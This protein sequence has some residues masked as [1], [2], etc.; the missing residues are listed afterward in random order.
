[1]PNRKSQE[2]IPIYTDFLDNPIAVGDTIIYPI[3][4]GSS[5]AST[6]RTIVTEIIALIPDP[7]SPVVKPHDFIREDQIHGPTRTRYYVRGMF[8]D[9]HGNACGS[10]DPG[11]TWQPLADKAFV[12]RCRKEYKDWRGKDIVRNHFL[13]N[14]HNVVVVTSLV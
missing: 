11:A 4:S 10:R 2:L 8:V 9:M 12:L 1:M 14:T 3:A 6:E 7:L 5:A 13:K